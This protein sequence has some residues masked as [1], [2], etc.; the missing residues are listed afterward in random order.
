MITVELR[1]EGVGLEPAA[2]TQ[3]LQLQPTTSWGVSESANPK[4]RDSGLWAYGANAP[5]LSWK[6]LEEGLEANLAVLEPLQ[7]EIARLSETCEVYWWI[8]WFHRPGAHAEKL[9]PELMH[10][11][12]SLGI[13]IAMN[14][15]EQE[16]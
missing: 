3:L 12:A 16:S 13:E 15:Y 1:I 9:S 14:A 4:R 10:R 2:V 11:L 6:S 5:E 8:G 7:R